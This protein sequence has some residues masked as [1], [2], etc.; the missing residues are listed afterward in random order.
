M[1]EYYYSDEIGESVVNAIAEVLTKTGQNKT[2]T[3]TLPVA[4]AEVH[5]VTGAK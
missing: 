5:Y 3:T 1:A 2:P 4:P